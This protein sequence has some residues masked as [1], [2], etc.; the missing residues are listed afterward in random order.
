[1]PPVVSLDLSLTNRTSYRWLYTPRACAILYVPRRNQH[2][3]RTTFPTSH[4][5]QPKCRPKPTLAADATTVA[6]DPFGDLFAWAATIDMTP[7]LCVPAALKFRAETFGGEEIIRKYC[8]ALASHGSDLMVQRL[9]YGSYLMAD[10]NRGQFCF[11]VVSL[12]LQ[13]CPENDVELI[14]EIEHDRT[15]PSFIYENGPAIVKW[16]MDKLVNEFNTYIPMKF[17][18]DRI[19]IRISAQTYLEPADYEWAAKVLGKLCTRVEAG[20]W[21]QEHSVPPA[22]SE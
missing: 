4:G 19:W 2:L 5:F 10:F 7:Y 1:M 22:N 15:R 21:R 9:G 20:E 6:V 17:Y 11:S 13:F 3:I 18:Q 8:H 12:P 14:R 16:I